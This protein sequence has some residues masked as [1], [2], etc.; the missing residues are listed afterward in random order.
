MHK[1]KDLHIQEDDALLTRLYQQYAPALLTH[2]VI[3]LPSRMDAEDV[4]VDVFVTA[5]EQQALL[6]TLPFEHTTPLAL[7]RSA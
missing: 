4:L 5:L 6:C 1:L 3:H 2:L 7:A